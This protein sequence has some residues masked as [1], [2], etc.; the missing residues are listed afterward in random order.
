MLESGF[1]YFI[2]AMPGGNQRRANL[3]ILLDRA[4]QFQ[5]TSMKGIFNFIKFVDKLKSSS[6][7]MGTAKIMGENDNVVKIMS[8]HKSKGLEFPVVIV[9]GMGKQFNLK[10][11]TTP[12]LF[13][14]DLGMGPKYVNLSLRCW[15]D[16]IAR[17][18]MKTKIKLECLSEEMRI[19]Y[20]ACTRAKNKLILI[21]SLRDVKK[22]AKKW[23]KNL[24]LLSI[25]NGRNFLDW[26]CPVLIFH[27]DGYKLRE[28]ADLSCEKDFFA[29]DNSKWDINIV[30]FSEINLNKS[31]KEDEVEFRKF[32]TNSNF[33]N[34]SNDFK[35]IADKL[36]WK[37]KYEDAVKIPSKM[38]VT[39]IK[40]L[41]F[42]D[43]DKINTEIP[44]LIKRPNFLER[45]KS[46]SGAEK[47]TITHFVMQHLKYDM[48]S[49]SNEIKEQIQKMILQELLK[50]EEADAV[51]IDKIL[52]FFNSKLGKRCLNSE[53]AYRETPFNLVCK[54]NDVIEGTSD[55]FENLL[56]Q[57]VIDLFFEENNE[58]VLVDYKTDYISENTKEGILDKYKIQ[59]AYY[60]KALE[61]IKRKKVKEIYIFLFDVGEEIKI[62]V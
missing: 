40:K 30:N 25:E 56:V 13:H 20:V 55:C 48:V 47:G 11:T 59:L 41:K 15:S 26:I 57:G 33:D 32:L 17:T 49:N 62:E 28:L 39:Q 8:I 43:L 34:K 2:S 38:S 44:S 6:G 42:S 21:G 35:I 61:N 14:K 54:T 37:Y 45:K 29:E 5:N 7:D 24:G 16:T 23:S 53:K 27:K 19:L 51:D 22:L 52:S 36:D 1:Y 4:K 50:E 60:K 9:A 3:D 10:D 12:V 18:A 31:K 46:F 58:L